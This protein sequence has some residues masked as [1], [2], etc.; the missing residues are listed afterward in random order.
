MY[1]Q[2]HSFAYLAYDLWLMNDSMK[3]QESDSFGQSEWVF[4]SIYKISSLF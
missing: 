3:Q 2:M 4:K 1:K